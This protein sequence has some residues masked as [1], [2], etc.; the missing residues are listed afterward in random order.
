MYNYIIL[1]VDS[2]EMIKSKEVSTDDMNSADDGLLDIIRVS[3]L[4]RY[5]AGEWHPLSDKW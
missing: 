2:S 4:T 5:D 1:M 3:D